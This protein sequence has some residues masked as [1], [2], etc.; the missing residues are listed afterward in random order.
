MTVL[1][2]PGLVEPSVRPALARRTR[3]I[4]AAGDIDTLVAELR[5]AA[6]AAA[7]TSRAKS[8]ERAY[9][10]DWRDFCAFVRLIGREAHQAEPESVELYA[11][12]LARHGRAPA[13]I[14]RRE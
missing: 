4:D 3:T 8:T 2:L 1:T 9:G 5:T 10:N 7:D 11:T 12:D 6:R 14:A 13:T